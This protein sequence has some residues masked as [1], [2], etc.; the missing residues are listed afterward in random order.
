MHNKDKNSH[1]ELYEGNHCLREKVHIWLR[2]LHAADLIYCLCDDCFF[3]FLSEN[4]ASCVHVGK[5][6]R[7]VFI[8]H[9]HSSKMVDEKFFVKKGCVL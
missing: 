6:W 4:V 8:F 7:P 5:K 2:G 9:G 3:C 1:S